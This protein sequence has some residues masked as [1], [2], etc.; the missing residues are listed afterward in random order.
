MR[1][2]HGQATQQF[3]T[4]GLIAGPAA[5][6]ADSI[7]QYT[8]RPGRPSARSW[9]R[10]SRYAYATGIR[11]GQP[12]RQVDRVG[13]GVSVTWIVF[14]VGIGTPLGPSMAVLVE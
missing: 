13:H 9:G 7:Q 11:C 3:S 8:T 14:G 12:S 6:S 1:I 10:R 2:R 5:S 4:P